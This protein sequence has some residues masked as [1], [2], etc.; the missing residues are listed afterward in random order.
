MA[1]SRSD[2]SAVEAMESRADASRE[3]K[4]VVVVDDDASIRHAVARMM[5]LRGYVPLTYPSAEALL[6]AGYPQAHCLVLDAHL[7]GL[8]GFELYREI[9]RL[10]TAPPVVFMTAYD[11]PKSRAAAHAAGA[12]AYLTKPFSGRALID[13]VARAIAVGPCDAAARE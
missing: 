5:R 8:D 3:G 1:R 13:A 4:C 6:E 10:G 11:E 7:P 9:A 12:A 2:E